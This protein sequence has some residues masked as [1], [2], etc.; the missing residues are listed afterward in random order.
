V[1]EFFKVIDIS[2]ETINQIKCKLVNHVFGMN[3]ICCRKADAK[4]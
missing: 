3:Q 4:F 2:M 1:N